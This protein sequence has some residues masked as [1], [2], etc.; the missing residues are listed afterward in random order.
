MMN[1]LLKWLSGVALVGIAGALPGV[2]VAEDA[3]GLM[4]SRLGTTEASPVIADAFARAAK[5]VTPEMRAKA[6]E[7]WSNNG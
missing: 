6:I 4:K 1:V 3:G 5:P 7:C 2:A